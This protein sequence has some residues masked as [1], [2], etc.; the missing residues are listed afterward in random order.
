MKK[1][2][3]LPSSRV[4][5]TRLGSSRRAAT[6]NI[7]ELV[8]S[9]VVRKPKLTLG[10][11][12]TLMKSEGFAYGEAQESLEMDAVLE[13]GAEVDVSAG[14]CRPATEATPKV[15][16][17]TGNGSMESGEQKMATDAEEPGCYIALEVAES[18]LRDC[19]ELKHS[20][21]EARNERPVSEWIVGAETV[22]PGEG[23]AE[24]ETAVTNNGG[25]VIQTAL[26]G[27]GDT[28]SETI[29]AN[30]GKAGAEAGKQISLTKGID[31][32]IQQLNLL[33]GES[34]AKAIRELAF[35]NKELEETDLQMKDILGYIEP[36]KELYCNK[37]RFEEMRV[38][39]GNVGSVRIMKVT[40]LLKENVSM[41]SSHANSSV[42]MGRCTG[43]GVLNNPLNGRGEGQLEVSGCRQES[44]QQG[45]SLPRGLSAIAPDMSAVEKGANVV[46][47]EITNVTQ[48]LKENVPMPS[49]D[50]NA[51]VALDHD[52][53]LEEDFDK[54][55]NVVKIKW[56]EEREE[57]PG[58]RFVA[59]NLIKGLMGFTPAD[60]YALLSITDTEFDLIKIYN[61]WVWGYKVQVKLNSQGYVQQHLP[62]SSFI[63]KSRGVCYYFGQP[64][65]CF[66]CGS[67]SHFA[68]K[69]TVQICAF[70]GEI[71]HPSKECVNKIRCNL[72]LREGHAYRDYQEVESPSQT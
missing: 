60:V 28:G 21:M 67:K 2:G 55:R 33:T 53:E 6:S 16:A 9:A 38:G 23:E 8:E 29:I 24:V 20:P 64:N 34:R 46:S 61:F 42:S 43:S 11:D 66:K 51:A 15:S 14:S 49:S 27:A 36:W 44:E 32:L 63:G 62:N 54:R 48:F 69:C 70:C 37:K 31:S 39:G 17:E 65:L 58:W 52:E 68:G 7:A 26:Q 5:K 4:M 45:V 30:E 19:M 59:R 13:Q 56:V 72:C 22:L 57:F 41:Q 71:G 12:E 3:A 50:V 10:K 18:A 1:K 40:E 25:T 47:G 35:L